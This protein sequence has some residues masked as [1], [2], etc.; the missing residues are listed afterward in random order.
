[1]KEYTLGRMVEKPSLETGQKS[2]DSEQQIQHQKHKGKSK[3]KQGIKGSCDA[4][5]ASK[6]SEHQLK[7]HITQKGR[8]P[9][10]QQPSINIKAK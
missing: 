6:G 3:S 7:G 1:M 10:L 2:R 8:A 5:Y 4:Y 9:L